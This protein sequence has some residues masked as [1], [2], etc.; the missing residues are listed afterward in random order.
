MKEQ[1]V[2]IMVD[3][4][5]VLFAVTE[6]GERNL[7]YTNGDLTYIVTKEEVTR[8]SVVPKDIIPPMASDEIISLP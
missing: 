8:K 2:K 5:G 4:N 1:E 7:I 3:R 6:D